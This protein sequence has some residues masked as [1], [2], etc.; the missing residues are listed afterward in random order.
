MKALII[1]GAGFIGSHLAAKLL[2][3]GQHVVIYDNFTSGTDHHL[4]SIRDN[5]N[6]EI[7]RKDV[8]D[9]P[10]LIKAARGLDVIYHFASNPDISKA[11]AQPDID[12]WEGT[13]LT[14]NVAE[15]ARQAG[16]K[17]IIYASGSGIYGDTGEQLVREDYSPLRPISTYGASKLAGEALLCSYCEMFGLQA[18]GFRFANVVGPR[19]THG[20]GY[21]FIR[22][23]RQNPRELSILG[24]GS[25]R[26]SYLYIDDVLDA[27]TA[28]LASKIPGFSAFNVSTPDVITVTQIADMV[29]QKMKLENVRYNY[30]GGKRGWKG[31]VPIIRLSSDAIRKLGWEP[32]YN[33][34]EAITASLDAMLAEEVE[35]A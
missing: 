32:K 23:L 29:C 5:A 6:L 12:F 24:D 33:S 3:A 16:V 25:Q 7:I 14:N 34:F 9:L 22:K 19:Q 2:K 26:K 17:Q 30:A 21:D 1:G 27:L 4:K 15:A 35:T 31:D 8:K 13:Y 18:S 10:E 28:V 11:A 20:V